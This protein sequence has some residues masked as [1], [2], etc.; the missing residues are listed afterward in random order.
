M[1]R[2]FIA[3]QIFTAASSAEEALLDEGAVVVSDEGRIEAVG[4]ASEVVRGGT[5]RLEVEG[6]ILP[7]LIDVHT[8]ICLSASADPG[9]DVHEEHPVRIAVR[10]IENLRRHLEAGVTT[11]RDV[12]G[13]HGIDL[14]LSRMV[15]KGLIE[16]PDV[17]AAGKVI[18][19][20][21]GHA[22]FMGVE[23]DSPDETR[24][25]AR[26]QMKL[27]ARVIKLIATGGVIT[28]GVRPGSPQLTE[29]EM[30]AACEEAHKASRTVA[31]HAQGAEGILAAL[32]AGVDTIEHG[33][34]LTDE[35]LDLMLREG[36]TLV[37]T[38][39]A[40]LAMQRHKNRLPPFIQ[41]K[42]D[43]VK[44]PHEAPFR[45]AVERGVRVATGTDAGTP[46]NPH[47]SLKDELIAFQSLGLSAKEALCS[48]TLHAA[49]ALGRSDRGV[50]E[51][52]RRADLIAIP[53][54]ALDDVSALA[55]PTLVVKAGRVL[56]RRTP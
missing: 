46:Y 3:E 41:E 16:G 30:R 43:E 23:C 34:W 20:T 33:F 48:A 55:P 10:A 13:V 51:P 36:R 47:G 26:E 19:M 5:E 53:L 54:A 50:L 24:K 22:C 45:R 11:I 27:G 40:L 44:E 7:G 8:H 42:L 14:E 9:R 17:F 12:G 4:P 25:A 18:C 52:G 32:R 1:T 2:A 37:P 6:A 49:A 29:E 28:P 15:D 31:A 56:R 35:A 38:C 39:A 21:G